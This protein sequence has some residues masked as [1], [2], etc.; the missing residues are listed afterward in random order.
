MRIR[1]I[2]YKLKLYLREFKKNKSKELFCWITS[3]HHCKT[4]VYKPYI[5]YF[6]MQVFKHYFLISPQKF[7]FFYS[8]TQPYNE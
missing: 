3:K 8:H 5:L 6:T 7:L 1:C 4:S 2:S